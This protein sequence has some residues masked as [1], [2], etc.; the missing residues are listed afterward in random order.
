MGANDLQRP[1]LLRDGLEFSRN[2]WGSS[3]GSNGDQGES[4]VISSDGAEWE[5][6]RES[7][8][9]RVEDC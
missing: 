8:G 4:R 3:S 7:K 6:Q 9:S 1:K 2:N 5:L